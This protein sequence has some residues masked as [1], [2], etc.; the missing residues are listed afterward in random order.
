MALSLTTPPKIVKIHDLSGDRWY[1][2]DDFDQD[3]GFYIFQRRFSSSSDRRYE[4]YHP[5][6][7]KR[8]ITVQTGGS[9]IY[10]GRSGARTTVTIQGNRIEMRLNPHHL[11]HF[12]GHD[13]FIFGVNLAWFE[14]QYD[15]DLGRNDL[16][17][18]DPY[19][20]PTQ[21]SYRVHLDLLRAYF[22]QIRNEFKCPIVRFW[23]FEG[24]EG[25]HFTGHTLSGID[26]AIL[27]NVDQ[28]LN[29]AGQ[30]GVY[31]YWCLLSSEPAKRDKPAHPG[32]ERDK[33]IIRSANNPSTSPFLTRVLPEFIRKIDNSQNVFAIDVMNEPEKYNRPGGLSWELIKQYIRATRDK[34]K[35]LNPNIF[36]S[37]G[38]SGGG[39]VNQEVQ[40]VLQNYTGLGLDF[41][42]YHCYNNRG[43]LPMS[44]DQLYG[45]IPR[46][47]KPCIIGEFGQD[48]HSSWND[49]LQRDVVNDFIKQTWH[50]GYAGC[51][52]WNYNYRNFPGPE[53]NHYS[54]IYRNGSPRPVRNVMREFATSKR[55]YT[56]S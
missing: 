21:Q 17:G 33:D 49:N 31:I 39:W 48:D 13:R 18:S 2:Y 32:F 41:Y 7:P 54:L 12:R 14:G 28:V 51:L 15:H 16:K 20:D 27:E 26:S 36:V 25:L 38:S 1:E 47:D 45:E 9:T 8:E 42:D 44:F 56:R 5:R 52:V 4:I 3:N 30:I 35:E 34:I 23:L 55:E 29:I 46:L 11:I 43:Q 24:C 6:Y 10:N 40:E 22:S 53:G 50:L 19:L 37:C